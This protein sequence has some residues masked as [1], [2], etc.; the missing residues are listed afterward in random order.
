MKS[1][2]ITSTFT[3][4]DGVSEL[5]KTVQKLMQKA[6]TARDNAYAPYSNFIV[7]AAV[8]LDNGKIILGNNQENAAYPSGLCAERVAIYS[9]AANFP[10]VEIK[11]LA[12]TAT[13]LSKDLEEPVAP[14]GACRQAIAEYESKQQ[15][16][17]PIYF[18]GK[19]G[20]VT[21]SDSLKDLLPLAFD[22]TFL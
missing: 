2:N 5:P 20:K 12:I 4:Y 13:A 18:M 3:I 11:A 15:A 7:G 8:L 9:A 19:I 14:C 22:K 16:S 1:I 10:N 17:I 21:K 6:I